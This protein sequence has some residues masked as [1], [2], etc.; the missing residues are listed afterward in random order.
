MLQSIY[1]I[2]YPRRKISQVDGSTRGSVG[3]EIGW[4]VLREPVLIGRRDGRGGYGEDGCEQDD[5]QESGEGVH[6]WLHLQAKG[7][8]GFPLA[9]CGL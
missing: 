9:P 4:A 5:G 1:L 7:T 8:K 2:A 6:E 3:G